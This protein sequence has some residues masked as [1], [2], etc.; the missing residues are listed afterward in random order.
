MSMHTEVVF[1]QAHAQA[2]TQVMGTLP[3]VHTDMH[4]GTCKGDGDF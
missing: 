3:G 1:D 4:T 2:S